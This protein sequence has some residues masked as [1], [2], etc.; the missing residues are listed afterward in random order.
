MTANEK[1][2]VNET[3]AIREEILQLENSENNE[4]PKEFK[5]KIV[6]YLNLHF[7]L[8]QNQIFFKPNQIANKPELGLLETTTPKKNSVVWLYELYVHL[9]IYSF[10]HLFISQ[11]VFWV[12]VRL[13]TI[14]RFH[15]LSQPIERQ[16]TRHVL[17][18]LF[19][20]FSEFTVGQVRSI[21]NICKLFFIILLFP[22]WSLTVSVS[23]FSI[24]L[25]TF[26]NQHP[27]TVSIL[28][29]NS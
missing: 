17:E 23:E 8:K 11:L 19:Q 4:L 12:S 27:Y 22:Y 14:S 15:L 6:G 20:F 29:L 24:L 10:F 28:H 16:R 25:T 2:S 21:G 7:G 9:F 13:L 18:L 26:A 3:H 1:Q 5:K